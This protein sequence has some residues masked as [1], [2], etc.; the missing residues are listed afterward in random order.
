MISKWSNQ[1]SSL[2]KPDPRIKMPQ[3]LHK[4]N[5]NRAF[6]FQSKTS[7]FAKLPKTTQ[8]PPENKTA[9]TKTLLKTYNLP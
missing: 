8:K 9:L 6:Q 5:I 3:E 4:P 2:L 1:L 7:S